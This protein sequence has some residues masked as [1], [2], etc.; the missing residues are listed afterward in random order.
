[1]ICNIQIINWLELINLTM[2]VQLNLIINFEFKSILL[3]YGAGVEIKKPLSLRKEMSALVKEMQ[4]LY[5]N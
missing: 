1:M 4:T 2:P 5:G 3:S